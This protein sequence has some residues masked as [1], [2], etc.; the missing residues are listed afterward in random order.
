MNSKST[1]YLRIAHGIILDLSLRLILMRKWWIPEVWTQHLNFEQLKRSKY[2]IYILLT[3]LHSPDTLEKNVANPAAPEFPK[4]LHILHHTQNI[5]SQ[6]CL[7]CTAKGELHKVK[8]ISYV[9]INFAAPYSMTSLLWCTQDSMY[10]NIISS[11]C[12][13]IFTRADT[14]AVCPTFIH[15]HDLRCL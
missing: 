13:G 15:N 11:A 14:E 1:W 5:N 10:E 3:V 6:I 7:N 8:E 2:I 9:Q 12:Y 4:C